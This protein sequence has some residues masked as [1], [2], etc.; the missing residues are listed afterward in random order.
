MGNILNDNT[1]SNVIPPFVNYMRN[2]LRVERSAATPIQNKDSEEY[3]NTLIVLN[4]LVLRED[5]LCFINSKPRI[6]R[7]LDSISSEIK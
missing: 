1:N 4:R 5:N 6:Y 7:L 2:Y 3:T